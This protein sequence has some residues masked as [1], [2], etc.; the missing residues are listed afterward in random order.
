M[1]EVCACLGISIADRKVEEPAMVIIFLGILL[2]AAKM[3]LRLPQDKL[4]ALVAILRNWDVKKRKTTKKG[5]YY[6]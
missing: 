1:L 6:H 2:D 3:E 5:S 4:K